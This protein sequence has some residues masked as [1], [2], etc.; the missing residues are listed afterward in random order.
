LTSEYL[1]EFSKKFEMTI[2][3]FEDVYE[4]KPVAKI[5]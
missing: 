2:M 5:C 4:K 1:S 3:L